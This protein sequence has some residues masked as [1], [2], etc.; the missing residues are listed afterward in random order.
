MNFTGFD[1]E[2]INKLVSDIKGYAEE[3]STT[4]IENLKMGV[5]SPI[6]KCWF[7]P[8]GV[9]YW[10]A[11]SED[12]R[13]TSEMITEAFNGFINAIGKA[14]QNWAEN[15]NASIDV[16]SGDISNLNMN[17][18]VSDVKDR[19]GSRMGII[20]SEAES[21]AS[22]L[23]TV[24]ESILSSLNEIAQKIDSEA[25]FLGREQ[26]QAIK[27][28]FAVVEQQVAKIFS[29]LTEGDNNVNAQIK[30][31]VQKYGD[32]GESTSSAFNSASVG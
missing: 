14:E 3:T 18:D 28:C 21:V 27:E 26:G 30:A 6:S 22:S 8:E 4:I 20:E 31:A 1:T 19:D 16:V 32:V 7:T 24:E 25:A 17:L 9:E 10:E 13:G 5:I 29:F 11:F 12:V 23:G 2:A 15:V